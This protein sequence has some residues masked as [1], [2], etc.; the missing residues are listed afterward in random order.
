MSD[1]QNEEW[2]ECDR[3]SNAIEH[4]KQR[5]KTIDREWEFEMSYYRSL[6]DQFTNSLKLN[7]GSNQKEWEL[8]S[9]DA[10][11]YDAFHTYEKLNELY[12]EQKKLRAV[13]HI[14]KEGSPTE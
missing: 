9:I 12:V 3:E 8:T 11:K 14:L 4:I 7:M 2:Y 13:L 5:L 1:I 10:R 6:L